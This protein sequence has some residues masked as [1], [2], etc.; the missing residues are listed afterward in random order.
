MALGPLLDVV[1]V[2]DYGNRVSCT[3]HGRA[4]LLSVPCYFGTAQP[5]SKLFQETRKLRGGTR[6]GLSSASKAA[7][8]VAVTL[9]PTVVMA[10]VVLPVHSVVWLGVRSQSPAEGLGSQILLSASWTGTLCYHL[11]VRFPGCRLISLTN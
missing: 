7:L 11:G 9:S 8:L 4:M 10:L 5:W 6:R 2:Q 1:T 3:M